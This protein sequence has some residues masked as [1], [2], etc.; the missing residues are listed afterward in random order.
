VKFVI[1]P[2]TESDAY[3]VAT[4]RY[5][6]EYAFY[7]A[8]ADPE[9]LAE[10]LNP[11]EWGRRY[12]VAD[13]DESELVGFFVFKIADE[14]AEIGLGLRPDL[15]GVGLGG[16]FLATGMQFVAEHFGVRGYTLAV[17]AFNDRAIT[18][19][20]RAGFKLTDRYNHSTNG[21]IHAFVRMVW[22]PATR[23]D[24]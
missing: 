8:D 7:D 12:F 16:S 3:A 4:W 24:A 5:P 10:L 15:T 20:Q 11:A 19:Y 21:G 1:R 22:E 14:V 23:D 2:M 6:A 13:N 18:V 9:D 17:A